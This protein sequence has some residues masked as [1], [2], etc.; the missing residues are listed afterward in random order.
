MAR[1]G[2]DVARPKLEG[3]YR[4]VEQRE[5]RREAKAEKAARLESTIEKE[6]LE[7]LRK[8]SREACGA[9]RDGVGHLWRHLQLSVGAVQ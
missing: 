7:R 2:A 3:I 4:K 5:S 9:V 6:L 8:V 1:C